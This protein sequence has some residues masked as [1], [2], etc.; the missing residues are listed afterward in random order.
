MKENA[1]QASQET[2]VSDG[3]LD[4][5]VISNNDRT[6]YFKLKKKMEQQI[7]K[8]VGTL[9]QTDSEKNNMAE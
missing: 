2:R 3:M 7:I 1:S 8:E 6:T 5:D 4:T 9:K